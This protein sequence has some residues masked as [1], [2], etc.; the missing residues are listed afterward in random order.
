MKKR[1]TKIEPISLPLEAFRLSMLDGTLPVEGRRAGADNIPPNSQPTTPVS[2]CAGIDYLTLMYEGDADIESHAE[3]W[4]QLLEVKFNLIERTLYEKVFGAWTRLT[5]SCGSSIEYRYRADHSVSYRINGGGGVWAHLGAER[6]R[7]V[8]LH[9]SSQRNARCTRIDVKV[10]DTQGCLDLDSIAIA[11]KEKNYKGYEMGEV[12]E[13]FGGKNPGKTIYFGGRKSL[14]RLRF[15]DKAAE[16]NLDYP[17]VRQELQCRG[18]RAQE[19]YDYIFKK[20]GDLWQ[21]VVSRLISSI[22]FG[23]RRGKNLNRMEVADFWSKWVE[24]THATITTQPSLPRVT[25]VDRTLTWMARSVAKAMA[26]TREVL[27]PRGFHR[28]LELLYLKG[29]KG[30]KEVDW[31]EIS[32][33]RQEKG[34]EYLL[35]QLESVIGI[36]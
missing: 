4:E 28:F 20:G 36:M 2:L 26:K 25:S 18:G 19:L 22:T 24:F 17:C 12:I 21:L 3:A 34:E 13:S 32:T 30:L 5:G 7:N 31:E 23:F 35:S 33:W 10:D 1:A 15:Y 6:L 11:L 27:T 16:S 9:H 29:Q 14:Q 8:Y